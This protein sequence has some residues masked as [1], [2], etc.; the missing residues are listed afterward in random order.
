MPLGPPA[1]RATTGAPGGCPLG[2]ISRPGLNADETLSRKPVEPSPS[3]SLLTRPPSTMAP[4][5]DV[6]VS[7]RQKPGPGRRGHTMQRQ[8]GPGSAPESPVFHGCHCAP[9]LAQTASRTGGR[10]SA[11]RPRPSCPFPPESQDRCR[12]RRDIDRL[13]AASR[14]VLRPVGL[15]RLR[16]VVARHTT[17]PLHPLY[18]ELVPRACFH[19]KEARPREEA[20]PP[21]TPEPPAPIPVRSTH[22]SLSQS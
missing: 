2:V 6:L 5:L 18:P 3:D 22:T 4:R 15:A 8:C 9:A 17:G 12:H 10:P 20:R 1:T 13:T 21:R 19:G 14:A 7:R 11:S 16:T